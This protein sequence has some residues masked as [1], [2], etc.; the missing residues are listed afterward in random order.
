MKQ[1][2]FGFCV[3]VAS[4][5][6]TRN[7]SALSLIESSAGVKLLA[8]ADL[9]TKPS[10]IPGGYEGLGF[11]GTAGGVGYGVLGYY[12]IRII[13]FIGAEADLEYQ[14]G[15]FH[16]DV[17]Y[18]NTLKITETVSTSSWRLPLLAKLNIPLGLGRLWLGAGPEFTIAQSSSSSLEGPA[19]GTLKTRDVKPTFFTGGLGLVIEVPAIG[20]DI[21]LEFRASKNLSQPANW[22]PD[23]VGVDTTAGTATVRAESSWVLRLGAG[24]G[25]RF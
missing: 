19:N 8:G 22:M 10:N 15:S 2:C 23:R 21:P 1:L 17:T 9:W 5:A 16:R 11:A 13:K 12:E 25:F 7:A 18:N 14:H 4:V 20:I 6:A 24:V 3:A